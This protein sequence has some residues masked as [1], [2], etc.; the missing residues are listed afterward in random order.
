MGW[1]KGYNRDMRGILNWL[2]LV[3]LLFLNWQTFI[4]GAATASDPAVCSI[5]AGISVRFHPDD[6]LRVGDLV[7]IEVFSTRRGIDYSQQRLSVSLNNQQIGS[8]GFGNSGNGSFI[9][10]LQ[11]AWDTKGLPTGNYQLAFSVLPAGITWTQ[12]VTL[13]D[14]IPNA[15]S[16]QWKTAQ[17]ACCVINYISN[18]AAGRDL[19]QILPVIQA[20]AEK[21]AAALHT[22]LLPQ[23]IVINLLPRLLGHGGFTTDEIYV[24]YPDH[25]YTDADFSQVLEHE[26]IHRLDAS[27]GGKYRPI[28]FVEGLAVYATG[29]HYKTEPL[30][31]RAAALY[32]LGWYIPLS[33]LANNF[34]PSQ[35]EIGYLEAS[36]VIAYMVDTWGWDA[37]SS[38]YRDIQG[39]NRGDATA[40]D[41]ALQRHF[42]ITFKQLEDR[43][44]NLLQ[45]QP[46]NP[47]LVNDVRD[48]IELYDTLRAYQQALDPSAYYRQLWTPSGKDARARQI[49]GDYLRQPDS[50]INQEIEAD[51][52]NA[53]QDLRA[54]KYNQVQAILFTIQ[55]RLLGLPKQN[56]S[57]PGKVALMQNNNASDLA[58]AQSH[59]KVAVD[60]FQPSPVWISYF[61]NSDAGLRAALEN[62][63]GYWQ[64]AP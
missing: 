62:R 47:D 23:K 48:T 3:S 45:S 35:H 44:V 17:T 16:Y 22:S 6:E 41:N 40:I 55:Q 38:F 64:A 50:P 21:A 54:G 14:A 12:T 20:R 63:A 57:Q 28:F 13:H 25:P 26:M 8:A 58:M 39:S 52:A 29:G 4:T 9:S 5:P 30:V 24:S 11:W 31:G 56:C 53:S 32:R 61:M 49:V 34:Y 27:L 18:T 37:F 46:V 10:V 1:D 59:G 43:Y 7:S 60:T 33:Y 42:S 2:L 51:L 36:T 19:S 15:N